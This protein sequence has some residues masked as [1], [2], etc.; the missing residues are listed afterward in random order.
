MKKLFGFDTETT[1]LDDKTDEI[2]TAS[3]IEVSGDDLVV[4]D[5][6]LKTD[7]VSSDEAFSKHKITKEYQDQNGEDYTVGIKRIAEKLLES[8]LVVTANGPFDL[9]M[10]QSSLDRHDIS[11]D[12]SSIKMYD[13]QVIDRYLDKYRKGS[14]KLHNLAK[15]YSIGVEDDSLHDASYDA[16]LSLQIFFAQIPELEKRGIPETDYHTICEREYNTQKKNLASYFKRVNKKASIAT[17]YPV[18]TGVIEVG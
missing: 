6:L 7:V 14:R 13:V 16:I 12:L 4:T 1:G 8:D 18:N 15:Y 11:I 9:T 17:G 2:V 5:W 10:L 3:I